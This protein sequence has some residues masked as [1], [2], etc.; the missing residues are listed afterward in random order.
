LRPA[1]RRLASFALLFYAGITLASRHARAQVAPP[2]VSQLVV[3]P[4]DE[5][6]VALRSNFGLILSHDGGRTWDW[7]GKTGMGYKGRADPAVAILRG[8]AIVLGV[9]TGAIAGDGAGCDFHPAAGIDPHVVD[10]FPIAQTRGAALAVSVSFESSTSRVW[11]TLDAGKRFRPLGS[12]LAHFTALSLRVSPSE[13]KRIY[14]TGLVWAESVRGAFARSE[15]GGRTFAVEPLPGS[16]SGSQPMVAGV[17]PRH[18]DVVYVRFTGNPG[19]VRMSADAGRTFR[20]VLSL[21]APL[22]AF[23]VSPTGDTL[24]ASSLE[25]GTY[26]ADAGSGRTR[27]FERIA[28]EGVPCLAPMRG[29]ITLLGC[30][31]TGRNGFIV[32]R[33]SDDGRTFEPLL[34]AEHLAP[35]QCGVATS[36]GAVSARE[37]PRVAAAIARQGPNGAGSDTTERRRPESP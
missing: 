29:K 17:D 3:E 31:A 26:R 8:G 20:E 35:A 9:S 30:G 18:A 37:W 15:D 22:Q 25:A 24:F 4:G 19:R 1:P 23:A 7:R 14:M 13:P 32:G 10:V 6:H 33:S 36:A 28:R 11:Q 34:E 5:R 21:P 16:D 27:T 12:P 2:T